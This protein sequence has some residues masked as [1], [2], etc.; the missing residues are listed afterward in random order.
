MLQIVELVP[1]LIP[2]FTNKLI[3]LFFID[4]QIYLEQNEAKILR[5]NGTY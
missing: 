2:E 3:Y 1:I 4:V 5:I